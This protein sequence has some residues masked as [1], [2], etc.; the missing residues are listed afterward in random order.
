MVDFYA[1]AGLICITYFKKLL[2]WLRIIAP[3]V[4]VF[5][6]ITIYTVQCSIVIYTIDYIVLYR[7][8]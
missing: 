3:T 8:R 7:V 2:E 5:I 4:N 1:M 6:M